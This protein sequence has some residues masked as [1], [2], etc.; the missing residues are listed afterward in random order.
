MSGVSAF[1]TPHSCLVGRTRRD[2]IEKENFYV[3]VLCN[4][5]GGFAR[6]C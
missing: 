2:T 1:D 5:S 4:N 6:G 3:F